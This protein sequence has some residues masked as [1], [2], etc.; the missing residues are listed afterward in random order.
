MTS[1]RLPTTILLLLAGGCAEPPAAIAPQVDL[2]P[3]PASSDSA[4]AEPVIVGVATARAPAGL[5]IDGD[6]RE[7]GVL[8][9]PPPSLPRPESLDEP[10]GPSDAK[11]KGPP[12]PADASSRLAFALTGDAALIAAELGEQARDGIWVG[13]GAR[14]PDLPLLGEYFGREG[15]VV[16]DCE[17][18]ITLADMTGAPEGAEQDYSF[19]PRLPEEKAA[20]EALEARRAEVKAEHEKRFERLFKIDREGVRGVAEDGAL[21]AIEGARSAWRPG[22]RGATVEVSLPLSAMPRAGEA[23]L[24]MLR[25][26]ARAAPTTP[27]ITPGQWVWVNLPEAVSF[28]PYAALRAHALA[29]ALDLGEHNFPPSTSYKQPWGMSYQPGD[30][31]RIEIMDMDGVSCDAVTPGEELLYAKLGS[32][33]DV[34]VGRV[35]APEG[36]L[37]TL[38]Y[39]RPW[40]AVFVKGK[41]AGM[42]ELK[43]DPRGA[44][45]RSGELHVLACDRAYSAVPAIW[46]GVAISPGGAHRELIVEPVDGVKTTKAAPYWSDVSDVAGKDVDG[47]GWRGTKGGRWVEATWRWD[48]VRK[49]YVGKQRSLPAPKKAKKGAR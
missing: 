21:V 2:T 3:P 10:D 22:P 17:R 5:V 14:V 31:L 35:A 24:R 32:L 33:G 47:F 11:T 43:G 37:C 28:E 42:I 38:R 23:P 12:N 15:F 6:L 27:V 48:A 29:R 26:V 36:N 7:W 44:V 19:E 16:L 46:S 41:L 8:P 9:A 4:A 25:L 40:V 39:D 1:M 45:E 34:E 20:C 13:I 30:A 49:R 18:K